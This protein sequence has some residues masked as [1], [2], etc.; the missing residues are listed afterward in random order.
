MFPLLRLAPLGCDVVRSE[1]MHAAKKFVVAV[2]V[3]TVA[4]TTVPNEG[5]IAGTHVRTE[6]DCC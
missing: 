3:A 1:H 6:R 4:L 2:A 5:L